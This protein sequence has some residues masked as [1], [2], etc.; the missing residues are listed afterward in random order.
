G[1]LYAAA[2]PVA[3]AMVLTEIDRDFPGDTTFPPYERA[4]WRETQRKP[5]TAADGLRFDF[6]LYERC[7]DSNTLTSGSA[8]PLKP[9]A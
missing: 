9:L 5:H 4:A 7:R 2:L 1:E 6:V 3:D 8:K